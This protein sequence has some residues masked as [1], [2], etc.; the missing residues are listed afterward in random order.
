MSQNPSITPLLSVIVPVYFN[1]ESL[2]ILHDRLNQ[3]SQTLNNAKFEFVFVDDRSGDN[4]FEV[5]KKIASKDSRVKVIRLSK[6]FGSFVACLAGLSHCKGDTATIIAADLQDPPELIIKFFE[7]WQQG[8]K[9]ICAVRAARE[10][11]PLKVFI[12]N[13]YYRLLRKYAL[14]EMPKGGFDSVMVDRKIIDFLVAT[15]E[16][17]TSLMGLIL[18]AGF[19]R[20]YIDYTKQERLHGKSRWTLSK[21]IKYFIDSFL[22]FSYIPI[23]AISVFGII[24]AIIAIISAIYIVFQTLFVGIDVKGFPTTIVVILLSSAIQMLMI[25]VLGE[26]IWRNLEETRKRPVFLVD[27]IIENEQNN[28]K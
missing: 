14:N 9:V 27:Q 17:N 11:N 1:A 6:N 10:E 13:I 21:K 4:S 16:K 26:Y 2:P 5:L 23:R 24:T 8:N 19:D 12:A 18:W 25:G 3:V 22:G 15:K 7:K 28:S 20:C